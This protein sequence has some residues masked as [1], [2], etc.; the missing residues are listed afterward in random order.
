MEQP[1]YTSL[2]VNNEIEFCEISSLEC[3]Q[4]VENT[5]QLFMLFID[6][7]HADVKPVIPNKLVSHILPPYCFMACINAWHLYK[8]Y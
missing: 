4:L 2:K 6:D 5:E 7:F 3:K 1:L 8:K